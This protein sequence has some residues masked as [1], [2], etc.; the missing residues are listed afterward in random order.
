MNKLACSLLIAPVAACGAAAITPVHTIP[1]ETLR[2]PDEGMECAFVEGGA[3]GCC[4]RGADGQ[5]AAWLCP[6]GRGGRHVATPRPVGGLTGVVEVEPMASGLCARLDDGTVRCFGNNDDGALGLGHYRSMDAITAVGMRDLWGDDAGLMTFGD[7]RCGRAP[8]GTVRCWPVDASPPA[9]PE[10]RPVR[11]GE[12]VFAQCEGLDPAALC[13]GTA[14]ALA[15]VGI[16]DASALFG[17]CAV[18]DGEVRCWGMNDDRRLHTESPTYG[19]P[20]AM[21]IAGLEGPV[22][23]VEGSCAVLASDGSVRCWGEAADSPAADLL[24]VEQLHFVGGTH[25]RAGCARIYGG[26]RCWGLS[27]PPIE[28]TPVEGLDRV[29]QIG[30]GSGFA[31]ALLDDG[32]IRC[33]GRNPHGQLGDGTTEDRPSPVTV[34]GID[35]A[36]QLAVGSH[37]ACARLEDGAVH[38]WGMLPAPD[39]RVDRPTPVRIEGLP[40]ARRVALGGNTLCAITESTRVH[41]WGNVYAPTDPVV[42]DASSS[43]SPRRQAPP[44]TLP[45]DGTRRQAPPPSHST[46]E[47][48][49]HYCLGDTGRCTTSEDE[50]LDVRAASKPPRPACEPEQTFWVK[51]VAPDGDELW[52]CAC[53]GD[54]CRRCGPN[55]RSFERCSQ[56]GPK[57]PCALP[58]RVTGERIADDELVERCDGETITRS[59]PSAAPDRFC[60]A[61]AVAR[62][63]PCPPPPPD[64]GPG[65]CAPLWVAVDRCFRDQ[66]S[67]E[68]FRRESA[69]HAPDQTDA[70]CER[71]PPK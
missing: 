46:C 55:D 14:I 18:Q 15:V 67:C 5:A 58:D 27:G 26:V 54:A 45:E 21:P 3:V 60:V 4:G 1:M 47:R 68:A 57:A 17:R 37:R 39:G 2:C 31:C 24:G 69:M 34:L 40:P 23:Y 61:G 30:V 53:R 71:V 66:R 19:V 63:R 10:C 64:A 20:V 28:V 48:R 11:R 41:C 33:W 42:R 16:D 44:T 50:C 6:E 29:A 7:H 32:S 36:T 38:C 12:G 59:A 49:T 8:D 65:Y 35:G 51:R 22:A 62:P 9:M 13:R 52:T 56:T 70:R 43:G 25:G